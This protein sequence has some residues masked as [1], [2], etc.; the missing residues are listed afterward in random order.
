VV[1]KGE[2]DRLLFKFYIGGWTQMVDILNT[3]S[4]T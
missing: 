2:E 3:R 4:I 1:K